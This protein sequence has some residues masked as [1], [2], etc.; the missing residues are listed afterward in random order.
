MTIIKA[1]ITQSLSAKVVSAS[2][3]PFAEFKVQTN[4]CS[5]GVGRSAGAVVNVVLKSG[6]NE[7]HGSGCLPLNV[8]LTYV[9]EPQRRHAASESRGQSANQHQPGSLLAPS[10]YASRFSVACVI[11]SPTLTV[12][13]LAAN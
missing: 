10:P 6:G 5:A 4:S 2:P 9:P 11:S 1:P 3:E 7:V 8:S 12:S 13:R